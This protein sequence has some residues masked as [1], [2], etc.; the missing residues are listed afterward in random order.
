MDKFSLIMKSIQQEVKKRKS[1]EYIVVSLML[2]C[3]VL[4]V[5]EDEEKKDVRER[6]EVVQERLGKSFYSRV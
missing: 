2:F 4:F 3:F 6:K 1:S 5:S